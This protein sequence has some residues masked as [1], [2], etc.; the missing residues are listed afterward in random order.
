[1]GDYGS[2]AASGDEVTFIEEDFFSFP[3]F[4]GKLP[5]IDLY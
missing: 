2:V 3:A 4:K 1:M 5:Y